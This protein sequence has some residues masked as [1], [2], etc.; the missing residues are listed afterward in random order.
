M[1]YQGQLVQVSSI[2]RTGDEESLHVGGNEVVSHGV[3]CFWILAINHGVEQ[4]FLLCW[5][6]SSVLN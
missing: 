4:V 2:S 3:P 6:V 1:A 5:V